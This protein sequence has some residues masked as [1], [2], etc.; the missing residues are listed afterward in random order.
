MHNHFS[1][2][3]LDADCRSTD[4]CCN[5]GCANICVSMQTN[6]NQNNAEESEKLLVKVRLNDQVV[7]TCGSIPT[8]EEIASVAWSKDSK[9]VLQTN[10][11]LQN[12]IQ[13]LT[14]GSLLIIGARP[15]DE[16]EY[17]CSFAVRTTSELVTKRRTIEVFEPASIQPG[18]RQV[19]ATVNRPAILDCNARGIPAPTVTWWKDKRM[20][21]KSS[22]RYNQNPDNHQL[23][24]NSVSS[25]DAGVYYCQAYN[26]HGN[27]YSFFFLI[28]F[29]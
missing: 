26:E 25:S 14:N 21:P 28:D 1:V 23:R 6:T 5:N 9:S 11:A 13:I 7:L 4:K 27:F 19:I 15:E 20:L 17:T 8:L 29:A 12:R 2:F 18:T 24:I 3:F 10:A 16:G 22:T